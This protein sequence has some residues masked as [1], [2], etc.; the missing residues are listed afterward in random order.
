MRGARP[1]A[2]C[3]EAMVPPVAM[4]RICFIGSL[5]KCIRAIIPQISLGGKGKQAQKKPGVSGP[6][7]VGYIPGLA[8]PFVPAGGQSGKARPGAAVSL[9]SFLQSCALL[10]GR[11]A[12][13]YQPPAFLKESWA[14]N[15]YA[16][17][18]F[19]CSTSLCSAVS[20]MLSVPAKGKGM[21]ML[22]YFS[23]HR[24]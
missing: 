3:R 2:V 4:S 7:W 5:S 1:S 23:R 6:F 8:G 22:W 13:P 24:L 10:S 14:K 21:P 18:A 16:P 17:S 12:P 15:F 11:K 9:V 19:S 20:S